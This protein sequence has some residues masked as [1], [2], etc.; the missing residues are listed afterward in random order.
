MPCSRPPGSSV[1][2]AVVAGSST[3]LVLSLLEHTDLYGYQMIE[4]LARRSNDVFQM[5]EGTLYPILHGLEKGKYLSSYEQQA[6]TGRMRKYYRLTRRGREL[7]ADKK[8]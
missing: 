5:K 6:P 4:E 7:L 1:P 3:L 2:K 8:T